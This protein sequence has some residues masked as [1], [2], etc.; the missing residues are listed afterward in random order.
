MHPIA[1][2]VVDHFIRRFSRGSEWKQ[3][4]E[5]ISSM[6]RIVLAVGGSCPGT[7]RPEGRQPPRES[8]SRS[9]LATTSEDFL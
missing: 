6:H 4:V 9:V 8:G 5:G 3:E 7:R 2:A 1:A